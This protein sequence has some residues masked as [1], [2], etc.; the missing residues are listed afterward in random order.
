[1]KLSIL[2]ILAIV[3]LL[4][5]GCPAP[6]PTFTPVPTPT[7][8]PTPTP[9]PTPAPTPTPTPTPDGDKKPASFSVAE[10]VEIFEPTVVRIDTPD[11]SGSGFIVSRTGYVVTNNHVIEG[12]RVPEITLM[13]GEKYDSVIIIADAGLDIA[14]LIIVADRSDFPAAVLGSSAEVTPGEEVLAIG[15]ALGLQGQVTFTKGIVSAI[16]EQGGYEFIQTDAAINPGNSG[17]P[18]V[19]LKGETIG[20]NTWGYVG[21]GIEALGFAIPIDEAKT[22][23]REASGR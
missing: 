8:T 11:G 9:A 16:L 20:I 19:N 13:T 4:L 12:T 1:M 2:I 22:L 7:L 21:S 10:T 14:I 5:G 15:Y 17:G 3:C 18:L 6:I 23:I